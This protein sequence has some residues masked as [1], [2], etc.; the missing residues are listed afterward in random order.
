M[1]HSVNQSV[2]CKTKEILSFLHLKET[3]SEAW[4]LLVTY[5][6]LRVLWGH[7]IEEDKMNWAYDMHRRDEKC[8]QS[9]SDKLRRID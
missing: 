1:T 5:I 9:L 3:K 8:R 4:R 2:C 7:Q 6:L